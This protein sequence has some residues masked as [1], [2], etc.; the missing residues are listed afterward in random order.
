MKTIKNTLQAVVFSGLLLS[1]ISSCTTRQVENND[2]VEFKAAQ[3]DDGTYKLIDSI[4]QKGLDREALYTL[5]SDIKP[6]SSLSMYTFPI[7]NTDS[8]AYISG[9]AFDITSNQKYLNKIEKIQNA[10]NKLNIPDLHFFV[11]PYKG[12]SKNERNMQ[13]YV[14]RKSAVNRVLKEHKTFFG[15]FGW[16]EG[17]DPKILVT[18]NEFGFKYDRLR[19]F[20]YLFGY[21]S[22]AV[23]FYTEAEFTNE[24]KKEFVKRKFFQIPT[25]ERNS[26]YFVYAYPENYTP[27]QDVDSALYNRSVKVLD[28]YKSIRKNYEKED[29]SLQ[30][31]KLIVSEN[32]K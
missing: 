17:V 32:L 9:N 28:H 21:P 11:I 1:S 27:K 15:Q 18:A 3:D 6:I 20:G 7:A 2:R 30:A 8:A 31:L 25:Y 29:G 19:G 14:A 12:A 13:I 24:K 4:L 10:M 16:V 26:G 5:L 22:H 23:D